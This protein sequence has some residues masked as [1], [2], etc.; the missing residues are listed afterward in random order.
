MLPLTFWLG[1]RARNA[2]KAIDSTNDGYWVLNGNGDIVDVNAGYCRMVGH[3]REQILRM[4][5]AD[6]EEVATMPRIRA[7]IRRI[8]D[9]GHEQFETRHRHSDGH[10]VDLEITVTRVD[11]NHLVAFL[12]DIGS[13]KASERAL[14]EARNVAEAANLAKRLVAHKAAANAGVGQGEEPAVTMGP[15]SPLDVSLDPGDCCGKKS[16]SL[17]VY[18]DN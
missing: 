16:S 9:R 18:F 8:M 7:Q 12:R 5:I 15:I 17:I 2:E 1:R 4:C 14:L 13:R 6:F 10:W 11:R 3:T